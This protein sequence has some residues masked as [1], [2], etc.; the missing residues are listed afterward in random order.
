[1]E[2][3]SQ[4]YSRTAFRMSDV[5][6]DSSSVSDDDLPLEIEPWVDSLE[7]DIDRPVCPIRKVLNEEFVLSPRPQFS[8]ENS[9]TQ[10]RNPYMKSDSRSSCHEKRQFQEDERCLTSSGERWQ[11]Q[12][13]RYIYQFERKNKN[14][15]N[16]ES[17]FPV[18]N[19]RSRSSSK[20]SLEDCFQDLDIDRKKKSKI[21]SSCMCSF[22]SALDYFPKKEKSN[23]TIPRCA[24]KLKIQPSKTIR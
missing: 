4:N 21:S 15:F 20:S 17:V 19:N 11:F 22:S 6:S 1:M 7:D 5:S 10:F 12:N 13:A 24:K 8:P 16:D 9:Q 3:E 23:S 14:P 18:V 2:D